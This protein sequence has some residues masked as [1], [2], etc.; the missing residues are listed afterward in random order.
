MT[1]PEPPRIKYE[2]SLVTFT[3]IP[4]E[5]SLCFNITGCPCN[6][7]GCFEPWLQQDCGD[8]LTMDVINEALEK[9]KHVTCFCFMGGDRY[10]DDVAVLTMELHRLYPN[11]KI[12]M[13]SGLA[14]MHPF[15]SKVLDYYKVGPYIEEFGPL[16]IKTTNQRLYKKEN[17]EWVDITYKFQK[18]RV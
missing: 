17:G 3:E 6:C 10:P 18:E 9:H 11:L 8:R 16:N 5:I 14:K 4:D 12:A 13:Y 15:L 7:K 1:W 2:S